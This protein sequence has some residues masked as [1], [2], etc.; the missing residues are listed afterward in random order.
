MPTGSQRTVPRVAAFGGQHEHA[1]RWNDPPSGSRFM[2]HLKEEVGMVM[3][4]DRSRSTNIEIVCMNGRV[5]AVRNKF[6]DDLP[7]QPCLSQGQ[8]HS[9]GR[10]LRHD[11][12]PLHVLS[13]MS[14]YMIVFIEH[15][16]WP[17]AI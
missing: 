17:R 12:P 7:L 16:I 2:S 14:V 3:R 11:F 9:V 1:G 10:M 13:G 6:I 8:G 5:D 15:S 4:G